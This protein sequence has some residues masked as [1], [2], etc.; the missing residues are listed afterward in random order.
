MRFVKTSLL[1]PVFCLLTACGFS[2]IYGTHGGS[3]GSGPV[4][5]ALN[6]VEIANIPDRNGQMLRNHL[7]DRMY[8]K[9][10]PDHPEARLEV[11]LTS[12]EAGLGIQKDATTTLY[13]LT[14]TAKY[15]LKDMA[16]K[17]LVSGTA[18]SVV[19][20]SQLDAQ[21]GTL[22]ARENATTRALDEVGEQIVNRLSLYLAEKKG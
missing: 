3:G 9:G 12:T 18:R 22:A 17:E 16:G 20:F 2:P 19:G 5:A 1:V 8:F 11:A 21:Y 6:K 13:E 4:D 7:I 15:T 14:L 10:R